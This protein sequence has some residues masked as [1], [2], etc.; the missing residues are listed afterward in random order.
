MIKAP[1]CNKI[2]AYAV[3]PVL[4]VLLMS[5]EAFAWSKEVSRMVLAADVLTEIKKIPEKGIP[6][7]LFE[8]AQAIAVIP[9]VFKLGFIVGARYGTGVVSVKTE[10]GKWSGP[11][12]IKL[13]GAS[14]GWQIG[15]QS[16]DIIL[17]FKNRESVYNMAKGKLT[18]GAD[19]SVAAGPVGRHAEAATDAFLRSEVYSY[20]R[21]RGLFAGI[22]LEGASLSI[23]HAANEIYYD[24]RDVN[25][26]EIFSNKVRSGHDA[27]K[28]FTDAITN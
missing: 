22:A 3:L 23:D 28:K 21:S 18:L 27:S 8:D 2:S 7:K 19:A 14:I 24:S 17:V 15:A 16:T 20:S 6:P 13:H 26:S 25:P 5:A 4:F 10:S 9:G 11:A 1:L 12:F